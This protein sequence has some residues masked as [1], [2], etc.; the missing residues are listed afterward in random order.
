MNNALISLKLSERTRDNKKNTSYEINL[1]QNHFERK[2]SINFLLSLSLG[3]F[4][5][6]LRFC[7]EP[8]EN[9]MILNNHI[10]IM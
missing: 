1:I 6:V 8:L 7:K 2:S 10:D 9:K 4:N 5:K 3:F